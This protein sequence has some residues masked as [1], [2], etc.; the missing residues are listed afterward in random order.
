[1]KIEGFNSVTK[2]LWDMY[3]GSVHPGLKWVKD[4]TVS[5]DGAI[6]GHLTHT[7]TA[8]KPCKHLTWAVI[9]KAF[10]LGAKVVWAEKIKFFPWDLPK[11]KLS[12]KLDGVSC[13]CVG[14]EGPYSLQEVKT[15]NFW[16][17]SICHKQSIK[18][19]HY[20]SDGFVAKCATCGDTSGN[21]YSG[22]CP[23]TCEKCGAKY[24]SSQPAQLTSHQASPWCLTLDAVKEVSPMP[25]TCPNLDCTNLD[26]HDEDCG[27]HAGCVEKLKKFSNSKPLDY[28]PIKAEPLVGGETKKMEKLSEVN[29]RS[30][31]AAT[32]G[33]YVLHE[34]EQAFSKRATEIVDTWS[35]SHG[36]LGLLAGK[37]ELAR[38]R[39]HLTGPQLQDAVILSAFSAIARDRGMVRDLQWVKDLYTFKASYE[40]RLARNFFDY[41]VIAAAGEARHC[42]DVVAFG[43]CNTSRNQV[44]KQVIKHDP[45][46]TLPA[47]LKIHQTGSFPGSG[48]GGAKWAMIVEAAILYF[49]LGSNPLVFADHC[50]DLAHNGNLA[51]DKGYILQNPHGETEMN[52]YKTMLDVKRAGA[53][54]E[55]KCWVNLPEP[56][57]GNVS[58]GNLLSRAVTL[59][60]IPKPTVSIKK[61]IPDPEMPTIIWGDEPFSVEVSSDFS[62]YNHVEQLKSR[63]DRQVS[64]WQRRERV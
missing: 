14:W 43:G 40:A 32:A 44:G 42:E 39:P 28:E 31:F 30:V 26:C 8:T 25:W 22:S 23:A 1:M 35:K 15:P 5:K 19:G 48:F 52:A 45:R 29:R 12:K 16:E 53:L 64:S 60:V 49:T 37:E 27:C 13:Y 47:L 24:N 2:T 62:K 50:V 55:S 57:K 54:L 61:Y 41:L 36:T 21:H 20:F 38:R 56:L 18:C 58:V 4:S 6:Y 63:G 7:T 34:L 11:W 51:F 33:L 17:C 3:V 10:A 46:S 59:G 9:Q